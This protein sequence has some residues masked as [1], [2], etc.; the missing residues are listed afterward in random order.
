MENP[1]KILI[2]K[3]PQGLLPYGHYSAPMI[4]LL[5]FGQVFTATERRGRKK[6]TNGK[7]WAGMHAAVAATDAWPTAKHLHED[8]KRLCGY[9]EHYRNPLTG[10][11]DER[12]QSTAFDAMSE[13]EFKAYFALAQMKFIQHMEFDPWED[14][15]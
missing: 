7:Y 13:P 1:P 12:V 6:P 8:L 9:V 4:D 11:E 2:Q 5:P 15:K 3:T 14:A 10:R